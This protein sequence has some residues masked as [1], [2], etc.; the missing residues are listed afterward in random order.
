MLIFVNLYKS[1]K[2]LAIPSK[3]KNKLEPE[4]YLEKLKLYYSKETSPKI[5]NEIR[6]SDSE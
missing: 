5:E 1:F 6:L 4:D 3:D 2:I